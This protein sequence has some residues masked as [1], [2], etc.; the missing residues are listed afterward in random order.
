MVS[1]NDI[2]ASAK[3]AAHPRE[4]IEITPLPPSRIDPTLGFGAP[5]AM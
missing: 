2:P 5:R 4:Q 3:C 1:G